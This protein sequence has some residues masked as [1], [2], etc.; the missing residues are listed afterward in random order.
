MLRTRG[1]LIGFSLFAIVALGLTY[2]MWS[3]LLR[4]IDGET[5]K[6]TATFTDVLGLHVGDDV[7]MAGVRVGRI[8][9]IELDSANHPRVKFEVQADQHLYGNTK[10]LVRYQNLIGQRYVALA[11]GPGDAAPL[12]AGGAIP[13]DRTEGSF[14]ISALLGGFQPLFSVLQPDQV[15]SLSETLVQALQGDGVS[16]SALI[17]E[18]SGLASTFEQRDVI[19]GSVIDN[20]GVVLAGLANRSNELQT[21]IAQT[22]GL[23]EGLYGQGELLKSSVDTVAVSTN[24]LVQMIGEVKPGIVRAQDTATTGIGLL[25]SNGAALDR[26]AI[27]LP[28]ILTGLARFSS[29]GAYGNAYLCSLDVSLWGI[30]LPRGLLTQVGGNQHSEVCR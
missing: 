15:N 22:R 28:E 14:D 16:L 21:L 20:L 10:A 26:A 13:L 6:Y 18:A 3:T 8:D 24:S 12:P 7:R 25:I 9:S 4:S 17:T 30:L 19:L 27:E 29:F 23:V 11:A 5:N 1:A 2:V